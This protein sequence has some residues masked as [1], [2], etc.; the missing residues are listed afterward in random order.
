MEEMVQSRNELLMEIAYEIKLNRMGEDDDE[1]DE[2]D[3]I[4]DVEDDDYDRGDVVAPSVAMPSLAATPPTVA[5]VMIIEEE[6]EDLEEKV[7]EHEALE[8]LEVIL[9]EKE[10]KPP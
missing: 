5:P 2:E 6:E 8:A 10:P 7:L 4:D 3:D 1:D 9:L